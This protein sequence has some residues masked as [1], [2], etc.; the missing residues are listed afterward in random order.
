[1]LREGCVAVREKNLLS[2]LL[3]PNPV[4]LLSVM[5]GTDH[6]VPNNNVRRN[7][8]T[9]SWLTPIDNYGNFICSINK[10]RHTSDLVIETRK[11]VLNVPVHGQEPLII[12]IGSSSGRHGD[13]FDLLDIPTTEPGFGIGLRNSISETVRPALT[14]SSAGVSQSAAFATGPLTTYYGQPDSGSLAS[15]STRQQRRELDERRDD[16]QLIAL[17]DVAAHIV[18]TVEG[19]LGTSIG[20]VPAAPDRQL[21]TADEKESG[22]TPSTIRPS[23]RATAVLVTCENSSRHL[24]PSPL[25]PPPLWVSRAVCPC[26]ASAHPA[27]VLH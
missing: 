4:C 5:T 12:S 23:P 1:M 8:M 3:Y 14:E 26:N 11:F 25:K 27:S 24:V 2:R 10:K 9:I 15:G 19:I 13:K 21:A 6:S 18:C 20:A 17:V 7:V 16:S 22:L